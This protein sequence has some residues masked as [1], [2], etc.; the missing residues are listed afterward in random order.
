MGLALVSLALLG[1]IGAGSHLMAVTIPPQYFVV[2]DLDGANDVPGQKDLSQ[3]G[4]YDDPTAPGY[5]D[6]FWSWDESSNGGNTLDA[7]ALFDSDG[8]GN[9][10]YAACG[11]VGSD[12]K[13]T[14][15]SPTVFSCDDT[16]KFHCHS[17]LAMSPAA[18]DLAAG[19]LIGLNPTGDLTTDTDPFPTGGEYP[20]DV[21]LRLKI[22]KSFFPGAVLTNVC[23]YPSGQIDTSAYSD[24]ISNVGGGFLNI[25]KN[26]TGGDGSFTFNVDPV[27]T[28]QGGTA[29]GGGAPATCKSYVIATNGGVGNVTIGAET[30]V[31]ESVT[32]VVPTG[33]TL[34]TASCQVE[35]SQSTTGS[36]D[37]NS[38]M[39]FGISIASGKVTTCT[40]SNTLQPSKLTVTKLLPNDNGGTAVVGN[41]TLNVGSQTV[42]SGQQNDFASG[43]Y[44][45]SEA[46]GPSGYQGTI[47]GDC[48]ANGG[49]H[50]APG[51]TYACTITND[52]IAPSLSLSKIVTIDNGGSAQPSAWTLTATCTTPSTCNTDLISG[53]G[54]A[55]SNSAF[56]AGTYA[57]SESGGP[58]GYTAGQWSCTGGG[59]QNGSNITLAVGQSASCSITNDDQQGTLIVKKVVINDNGGSKQATD[60]SF[61]VNGGS[62]VAF[63]QDSDVLHGKKELAVDAASYS[64]VE[65]PVAGYTTTY[66]NCSNVAVA[67]GQTQTCT[68]TNDDQQATLVVKKVVVNNN[69][70]TRK[71]TDFTFQVGAGNPVAFLQDFDDLHGS[72]NVLV[73]AG[74]YNVTEPAVAGYT[75]T[76][77][78]CANVQLA[79]GETKTCT[80]T[81]DD[82]QGKLIV[83][84]TV[85][86]DNNGAKIATDFTFQVDGGA[87]VAFLQDTDALHGKNTVLRNAGTYSITEPSVTGYATSYSDCSAIV[88]GIGE[89]KTCTITNNDI[90]P[91]LTLVKLVNNNGINDGGS[92]QSSDFTL[93]AVGPSTL[94][95]AGGAVSNAT[96]KA[97]SYALSEASF[98][99]YATAGWSCVK[100]NVGPTGGATISLALADVATCTITNNAVNISPTI[101]VDKS[102]SPG[103]LPQSGGVVTFTVKVT[104]TSGSF[105]TV[106]LNSLQDNVYGNLTVLVEAG[107]KDQLSTTCSLP[108]VIPSGASYTC[109]FTASFAAIPNNT[110]YSERDIV[111]ATAVDDDNAGPSSTA[112][113]SDDAFVVQSPPI[114]VTNS[115]LC[116]FDTN[117]AIGG[118]QFKR[119]FTQDAQN[120]PYY[121]L[122]ATNPGQFYYNL[123]LSGTPGATVHVALTLPWPFVTQGAQPIHVY[124]GV[125]LKSSTGGAATPMDFCFVPG[126]ETKSID[127]YVVLTSTNPAANTKPY[128]PSLTVPGTGYPGT[129]TTEFDVTIPATGFAYINQ[130]LDDGLKGAKVDLTGDGVADTLVYAMNNDNALYPTSSGAN[131]GKILVPELFK[132]VFGVLWSGGATGGGEDSIYND[133][134][135][136]KNT[137]VAGRVTTNATGDGLAGQTVSLY[138]GTS[139]SGTPVATA[140]TDADGWYTLG[141][142]H[143]GKEA[144]YTVKVT[145]KPNQAAAPPLTANP[146]AVTLKANGFVQ[147]DYVFP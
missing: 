86:N 98:P 21:T 60:F 57:L 122:T 77:S 30:N 19:T 46:G 100:N 13:L 42:V 99:G 41:F 85:V 48:A 129:V 7:C 89:E 52:D 55:S 59:S 27:A 39:I 15:G 64:I 138:M 33:W 50:M 111:T 92:R 17:P 43:D 105:D 102:A 119:L 125:G 78:N 140:I 90:A 73:N 54:G 146:A 38:K 23:T 31:T 116:S 4:R 45:I 37:P 83:K 76:Y 131:L 137:G 72:N 65:V 94:S 147:V 130:H 82:Q 79:V 134:E 51:Q 62:A 12:D 113:A 109:T 135:F 35:G 29:C 75:T 74:T 118:R 18:G 22:K 58:S 117:A 145:S 101:T 11:S 66:D 143:T 107:K 96:F 80:I 26:A 115:S 34:S 81:N 16:D 104:N 133:N 124:D 103:N 3:M 112:T 61:K 84:K 8:D 9:I 88:L 6:I 120:M 5:L 56:K 32:E 63:L 114:A 139:A 67:N 141:Y 142:K 44:T 25:V 132:H 68:I 40:F 53:A 136:K 71:A 2:H 108:Q 87:A 69:G 128:Y 95:G 10:N 14:A 28:G 20:N 121:R 97:G 106:T 127:K 36:F 126:N 24:C 49:L 70:G 123:S 47:G 91:S 144:P 1:W 93:S 110:T